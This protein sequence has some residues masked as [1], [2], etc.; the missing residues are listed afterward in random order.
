MHHQFLSDIP[1][2]CQENHLFLSMVKK[3]MAVELLFL[4]ALIYENVS[5]KKNLISKGMNN[6]LY[7]IVKTG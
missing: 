7:Y 3:Y 2:V 4:N 1:D 6:M 5:L